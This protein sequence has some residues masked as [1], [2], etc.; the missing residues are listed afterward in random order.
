MP[1][2]SPLYL[3][4]GQPGAR[5]AL[6]E[7][8]F[9][10]HINLRGAGA[11]SGFLDA[12]R[13]AAGVAPPLAPN[14]VACAGAVTIYWLGPDEWQVQ[15]PPEQC[16]A[17]LAQLRAAL[18]GRHAAVTDVSDAHTV[19]VLDDPR[20]DA[21]LSRGCPLDFHPAVFPVGS[22]AQSVFGK[23]GVLLLREAPQRFALVVRRS[24]AAYLYHALQEAAGVA[25]E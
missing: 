19:I 14:T 20:A 17:L 9:L 10:G 23:T 21:L 25:G 13:S 2:N 16:A 12:V 4:A 18:A 3:L 5:L 8:A 7:R 15:A 24:F 6:G 1:R 22:C 11:D